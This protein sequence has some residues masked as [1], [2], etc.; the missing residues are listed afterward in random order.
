MDQKDK[1]QILLAE[2]TTLRSELIART[3]Y[4]FQIEAAIAAIIT[5]LLQQPFTSGLFLGFVFVVLGALLFAR[6]N[7]RDWDKAA[8]EVRDL[9]HGINSRAGE[10]LLTHERLSRA[11][12][13]MGFLSGLFDKIER[14]SKSSLLR[15][16][17]LIALTIQTE[18][19]RAFHLKSAFGFLL[20]RLVP[21]PYREHP[22]RVVQNFE[23]HSIVA[24]TEAVA[25]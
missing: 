13:R 15:W 1:I 16:T 8:A 20:I 24:N 17:R 10:H 12:A 23:Y 9:E 4:G 25:L 22:D 21:P 5:W 11:A 18:T 6:V 7:I 2:Y 19:L 3:G 14:R